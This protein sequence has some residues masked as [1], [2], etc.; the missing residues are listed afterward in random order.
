MDVAGSTE[1]IAVVA[2]VA[3]TAAGTVYWFLFQSARKEATAAKNAAIHIKDTCRADATA[4]REEFS[5]YKLHVA[6]KYVTQDALTKS[7]TGLEKAIDR[8]LEAIE[9]SAAEQRASLESIHRR[10]DQKVDK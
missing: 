10:I 2:G 5:A 1:I 3:A 4:L 9:K 7:V 6:E 8:L